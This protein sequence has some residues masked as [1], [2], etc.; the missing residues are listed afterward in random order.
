LMPSLNAQQAALVLEERAVMLS[1]F[2][3]LRR[4]DYAQWLFERPLELRVVALERLR[5]GECRPLWL[6]MLASSVPAGEMPDFGD[7][8]LVESGFHKWSVDAMSEHWLAWG[9]ERGL[10]G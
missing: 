4:D 5:D 7:A 10:V 1:V 9:R 2:S 6:W 8:D 3:S